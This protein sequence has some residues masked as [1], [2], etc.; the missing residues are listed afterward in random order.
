MG[1]CTIREAAR[2]PMATNIAIGPE[3]QDRLV[4]RGSKRF[5]W[6]LGYVEYKVGLEIF[7]Y[8]IDRDWNI[9]TGTIH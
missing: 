5:V 3:G 4:V 6:G 8:F 7:C 9:N 1:C 2:F